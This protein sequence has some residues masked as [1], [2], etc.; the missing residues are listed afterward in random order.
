M[1]F[2]ETRPPA[3][4]KLEINRP[5]GWHDVHI[6]IVFQ[7]FMHTQLIVSRPEMPWNQTKTVLKWLERSQVE[8]KNG[9]QHRNTTIYKLI[10]WNIFPR[11][12]N[13]RR[14]KS[15]VPNGN[16]FHVLGTRNAQSCQLLPKIVTFSEIINS[17]SLMTSLL[18]GKCEERFHFL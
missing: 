13:T 5:K 4:E 7:K 11:A 2:V 10:L 1:S 3:H 6:T 14:Q 9:K 12:R 8:Q 17:P 15:R 16:T 18:I